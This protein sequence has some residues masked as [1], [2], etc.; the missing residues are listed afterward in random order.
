[1]DI[2]QKYHILF[3]V[4]IGIA[5]FILILIIIYLILR[6]SFHKKLGS[7][8]LYLSYLTFVLPMWPLVEIIRFPKRRK[9]W[10][11]KSGLKEGQI[12]LEEGIGVGTSPLL[13]S[14][15]VGNKGIVY[16]LDNNPL[17]IAILCIRSKI[18][19]IKNIK[20]IFSDAKDTGLED[21]SIDTIFICD[22]FHEFTDKR[23]TAI[24][25]YR[26]L[27]PGGYLSIWDE[28]VKFTNNAQK[29][30][31]TVKLFKLIEREKSYFKLKK[32]Q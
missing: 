13:A 5:I 11:I 23:S 28:N 27:K 8:F 26:V 1:M 18:R 7:L 14:R 10:L 22:A 32:E 12:Y 4:L 16:A 9:A 29:I 17:N 6:F 24:E 30:F 20:I 21:K 19:R 3:W 15:I 25:L 31:E 2:W